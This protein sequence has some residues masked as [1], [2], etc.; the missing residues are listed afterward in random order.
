MVSTQNR[1]HVQ[2]DIFLLVFFSY[3]FFSSFGS[4]L[5]SLKIENIFILLNIVCKEKNLM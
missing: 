3:F 2:A 5:L 1:V 4:L